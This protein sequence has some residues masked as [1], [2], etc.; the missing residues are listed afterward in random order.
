MGSRGGGGREDTHR[1]TVVTITMQI[2]AGKNGW[3]L[4]HRPGTTH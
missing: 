4:A 2:A 3:C 1:G